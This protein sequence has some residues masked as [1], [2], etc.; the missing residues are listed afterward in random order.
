MPG[1]RIPSFPS[2]GAI[3]LISFMVFSV[4]S[5]GWAGVTNLL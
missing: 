5:A 2:A 3:L 1:M 4:E